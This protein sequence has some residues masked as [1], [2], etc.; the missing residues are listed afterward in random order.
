MFNK[1]NLFIATTGL[2]CV[3]MTGSG[4]A[5]FVH[6]PQVAE[7]MAKM[8]LPL[9]LLTLI[10]T[11]KLLG[12]VALAVPGYARLKEW[13]YAGFFFDLT[14]A[15]YLHGAVGDWA[16]VPVPLVLLGFA[17]ASWRLRDGQRAETAAQPSPGGVMQAGL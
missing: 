13:T 1:R 2:F 15:A 6:P 8:G 14:G 3:A 11:W 5:N 4:I 7:S 10:G 16:G 17:L 12:V 9:H